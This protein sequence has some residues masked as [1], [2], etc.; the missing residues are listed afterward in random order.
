MAKVLVVDD[1]E[2][3]QDAFQSVLKDAGFDVASALDGAHGLELVREQRPDVILLDMMMPELD[4]LEFLRRLS[5]L[6][7]PPP[8]VANSGFDGFRVEALRRGA[9]AFLLKPLSTKTLIGALR[10]ALERRP[11]QPAVLADNASDVEQARRLALE[12]TDRAVARLDECDLSRL[13]EGLRRVARWLPTYFGFGTGVVHLLRGNDLSLEAIYDA[14]EGFREGLRYPRDTQYC[15]D[16]IAAGS[17]LVLTDPAHHPC[18]HFS[19]HN[20]IAEGCRF[21][22]GVPLKGPSGAVMGTLCVVDTSAHDFRTE[23]MR[24]LEALGQGTA[25]GL[26]T[27]VWPLDEGSTFGRDYLELFLGSVLARAAR[28]GGAGMVMTV[29]AVVPTPA[30]TGLAVIR[31]DAA[32]LA[33]LWGGVA[34]ARP[35][36]VGARVLEKFELD[37]SRNGE[38]ARAHLRAMFA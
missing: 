22:V 25:R 33:L 2:D 17:T 13:R 34:R 20:E 3:L 15:D 12:A 11:P 38:P 8:V 10:S 32:R 36:Q 9:L 28:V 4:G 35:A 21:Y 27:Q 5:A 14:P 6:P 18:D 26:E 23:D 7:S 24:V 1:S 19:H 30:G 16:V 31:L 29:E 37:A